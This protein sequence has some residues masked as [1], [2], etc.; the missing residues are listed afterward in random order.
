MVGDGGRWWEIAGEIACLDVSIPYA[1]A[2]RLEYALEIDCR[3][4]GERGVAGD[5][6]YANCIRRDCRH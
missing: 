3:V 2:G 4:A 1:E 5:G 6:N